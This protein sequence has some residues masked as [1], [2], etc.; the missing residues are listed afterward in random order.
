MNFEELQY[1]I[2]HIRK[3]CKCVSCKKKYK[4]EDIHV[5][6]CTKNEALMELHCEKC[7]HST[8]V[9]VTLSPESPEVEITEKNTHR[10]HRAISKN[11]IL[12]MKNFLNKFDGNFK[13]IFNDMSQ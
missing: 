6:A 5:I 9:T 10:E 12:D 1:A 3:S 7:N 13:K 4:D 2:E 11:D 8:I